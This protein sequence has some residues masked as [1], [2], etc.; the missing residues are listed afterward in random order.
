MHTKLALVI[1]TL[2]GILLTCGL[3]CTNAAPDSTF[4]RAQ[5]EL[6]SNRTLWEQT[7]SNDYTYEYNAVCF[8]CLSH[9]GQTVKVTVT[10]GD[11]ESVVYAESGLHGESGEPPVRWGS[12]RGS[13]TGDSLFDIIPTID[14]LFDV[15]QSAITREPDQ[16]TVSYDSE[17]GYPTNIEI[18][19]IRNSTDDEYFFTANAY[20]PR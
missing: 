10:N 9:L 13:H 19:G 1:P 20:S 7:R 15:V 16:L 5:V 17:F 8:A 4:A 14:S 3:A 11:I 2:V 6:D 12:G 18:D